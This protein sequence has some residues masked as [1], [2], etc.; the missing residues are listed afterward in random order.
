MIFLEQ[1]VIR[2]RDENLVDTSNRSRYDGATP[3]QPS[4]V[5]KKVSGDDIGEYSCVLENKVGRG[6]SQNVS[7]LDVFCEYNA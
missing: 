6:E 3:E 4:L 2:Y 7:V 1:F 5:I